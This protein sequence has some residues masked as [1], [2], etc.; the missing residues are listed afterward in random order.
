MIDPG[1]LLLIHQLIV[2]N[3]QR[4]AKALWPPAF[5]PRETATRDDTSHPE[6]RNEFRR[7][8][9]GQ[10]ILITV[11]E[12]ASGPPEAVRQRLENRAS[13]LIVFS[14]L[15]WSG[16]YQRPQHLLT[17]FAVEIP[18]FVIEEPLFSADAP[19]RAHVKVSVNKA[20]TILTPIL[21]CSSHF[22]YGFTAQ[23]V[24]AIKRLI[25][26]ILA[27]HG[28]ITPSGVSNIAGRPIVWYYTPM[29]LGALPDEITPSLVVFDAM[30]DLAS[31]RSAP[32]SLRNQEALMFQT[33]DLIFAGGPTLYRSRQ[34]RHSSVHCFPSG[35]EAEHFAQAAQGLPASA[36]LSRLEGPVIGFYGVLDERIDFPLIAA[37]AD[38]RPDWNIA[39]IGPL[40]KIAESDLPRRPNIS[41][42]GPQA[43]ADLPSFLAGFNVAILP[44]A[45]NEATRSI[46]PTK[47]LEYLAAQKPVVSTNIADVVSLY[48]D[49]VSVADDATSFIAAIDAAL[50]E[51]PSDQ[52]RRQA[53][54][55]AHLAAH[56]WDVIAAEMVSLMAGTL[57]ARGNHLGSAVSA[58]E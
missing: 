49:A 46:S 29:A 7:R 37:V 55:R 47:T 39:M 58:E 12:R 34:S 32:E 31:F 14:H 38:A 1:S 10:G 21:P 56:D 40:A 35:V 50:A 43:Y 22:D 57:S 9:K 41:Y 45:L 8:G 25:A 26:P 3:I 33:A 2:D 15:R 42:H 5:R 24:I 53:A 20:V 44:F 13:A 11:I 54:G 51:S 30:D 4:S 17:R 48:G 23:N 27:K 16:V 28:L 36:K 6:A 52:R 19:V 18:V